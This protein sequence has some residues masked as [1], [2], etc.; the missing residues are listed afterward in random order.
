MSQA[1][2]LKSIDKA[3]E[4]EALLGS[5]TATQ[6]GRLEAWNAFIRAIDLPAEI[7]PALMT[8]RTELLNLIQPKA[9]SAEDSK[10]LFNLI[11]VLIQTNVALQ[12]HAEQLSVMVDNWSG[13]FKHLE[14]L[15]RKV[16]DFAAFKPQHRGD[17]Q[18]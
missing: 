11:C 12:T 10:V 3:N 5:I 4:L 16:Q 2:K 1:S 8:G 18:A 15:G 6:A 9:L 7:Y 13:A 14:S 17:E